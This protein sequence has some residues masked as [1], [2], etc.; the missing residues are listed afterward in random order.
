ME[1]GNLEETRSVSF[2]LLQ[3][4]TDLKSYSLHIHAMHALHEGVR[5]RQPKKKRHDRSKAKM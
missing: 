3:V 4:A 1:L 5:C 2:M